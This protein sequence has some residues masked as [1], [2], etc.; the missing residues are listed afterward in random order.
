MSQNLETVWN[1][2]L[3]TRLHYLHGYDAI[4]YRGKFNNM[5]RSQDRPDKIL[6]RGSLLSLESKRAVVEYCVAN[7]LYENDNFLYDGNDQSDAIYKNWLKFWKSGD[8]LLSGDTTRIEI[9]CHTKANG[10]FD[11]YAKSFMYQDL[12]K[13]EF[14]RETLCVIESKHPGTVSKMTGFCSE[15]VIDRILKT[16]PFI[17]SRLKSLEESIDQSFDATR[18]S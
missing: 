17:N 8:Y 18:D 3:A 4:K 16:M 2:Y 11:H 10:D 13:N 14:N 5:K 12:L 15:G 7:F 1:L 9:L 6:A